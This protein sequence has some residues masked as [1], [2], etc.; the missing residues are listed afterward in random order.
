M[1]QTKMCNVRTHGTHEYNMYSVRTYASYKLYYVRTY[2]FVTHENVMSC[3]RTN[4]IFENVS[5]L[6]IRS[7]RS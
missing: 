3:V 2:M 6:N 7:T 1:L 5:R 4:D